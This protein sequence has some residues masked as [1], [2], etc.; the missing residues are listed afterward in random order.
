MI[1][2]K[3]KPLLLFI[4]ALTSLVFPPHA[5]AQEK[6]NLRVVF[7]SLSWNNQLPIRVAMSKGF[8]KDQGLHSS[9]SSSA[10]GPSRLL[11]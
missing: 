5:R 6:K 2:V 9:R 1:R 8:F 7:V 4:I 3:L 10:A 11:L